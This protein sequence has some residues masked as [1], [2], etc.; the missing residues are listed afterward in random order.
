MKSPSEWKLLG[1]KCHCT[2][3][4]MSLSLLGLAWV[5]MSGPG[6][7]SR[8]AIEITRPFCILLGVNT[9]AKLLNRGF[10]N[11]MRNSVIYW[12]GLWVMGRD[13]PKAQDL[14]IFSLPNMKI[15]IL[16]SCGNFIFLSDEIISVSWGLKAK[17]HSQL[18]FF[19]P[20]AL[21]VLLRVLG[22]WKV[23]GSPAEGWR[24]S[25]TSA[26]CTILE[27]FFFPPPT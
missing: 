8:A 20:A 4:G 22:S 7:W 13:P 15:F 14:I 12:L 11:F 6:L 19:H 23:Q 2:S 26:W 1:K 18:P 16:L 10:V 5:K 27:L 21:R 17:S 3:S 9:P 24:I 25:R